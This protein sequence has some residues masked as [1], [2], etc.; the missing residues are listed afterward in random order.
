[1]TIT[2]PGLKVEVKVERSVVRVEVSKDGNAVGPTSIL[3][4]GQ[5]VFCFSY[6]SCDRCTLDGDYT[7]T[8][9]SSIVKPEVA[10]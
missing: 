5:F 8:K 4:R 10:V 9:L 6:E 3:G 2:T 1:M 7:M